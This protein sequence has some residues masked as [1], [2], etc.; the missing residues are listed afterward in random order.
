[1]HNL[2][3]RLFPTHPDHAGGLGFVGETQRFFGVLLFAQSIGLAGVIA[4]NLVYDK[5]PLISF[6]PVL[7]A[8]VVIVL[9]LILG[10]LVIFAR[11]MW[12]TKRHGLYQYGRLA[13]S[14]TGSF[15][16]KWIQGRG[17]DREPLLGT[18]DI[19]SLADL[20]NSYGIIQAM[21][22]LPIDPRTP[23]Y[24][25]IAILIPM[26]PLLLT[27]MPFKDIIKLLFKLVA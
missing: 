20:G 11:A 19:Q 5:R 8:Y 2:D 16:K 21:Y 26:A 10:P 15:H 4:N 3:L 1:M 18:A 25:L 23:I 24:L 13:T 17:P 14:Y 7:A 6:A 22:L 27:V 12:T 9:C